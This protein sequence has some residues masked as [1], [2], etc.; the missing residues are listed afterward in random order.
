MQLA[1][2]SIAERVPDTLIFVKVI[3]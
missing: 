2:S 1:K 3:L